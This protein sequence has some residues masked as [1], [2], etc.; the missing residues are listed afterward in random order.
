VNAGFID[1][2]IEMEPAVS[3]AISTQRQ[4][5]IK[6]ADSLFKT[7]HVI[8]LIC[9]NSW[10]EIALKIVQKKEKYD[11]SIIKGIEA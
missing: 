6:R 9:E 4:G 8:Q 10:D 1:T 3:Y 7:A 2:M 11:A 5:R